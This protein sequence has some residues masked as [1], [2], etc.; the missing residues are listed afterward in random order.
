MSCRFL[1]PEVVITGAKLKIG[2]IEAEINVLKHKWGIVVQNVDEGQGYF[3]E[4]EYLDDKARAELLEKNLD[5]YH[6]FLE[7]NFDFYQKLT[8]Q[9]PA[10]TQSPD[11]TQSPAS[12][13]S[14]L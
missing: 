9:S 2:L 1:I 14:P 4:Q 6:E 7:K 11:S 10:S 12:A 5:F 8:A 3:D 13:Q